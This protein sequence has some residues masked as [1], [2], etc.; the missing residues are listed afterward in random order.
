MS[1][2]FYILNSRLNAKLTTSNMLHLCSDQ[3]EI[4]HASFLLSA[5]VF[6]KLRFSK[7]L[8]LYH[9]FVSL[10]YLNNELR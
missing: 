6:S 1:S 5:D 4:L 7:C 3:W 8:Y 2:K 9:N 10:D